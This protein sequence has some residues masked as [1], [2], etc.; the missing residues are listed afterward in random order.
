MRCALF[1]PADWPQ[2]SPTYQAVKVAALPPQRRASPSSG[3]QTVC[4]SALRCLTSP[5]ARERPLPERN[6]HSFPSAG[7]EAR[8]F[9]S[10]TLNPPYTNLL[11]APVRSKASR[12]LKSRKR[13]LAFSRTP[14][15]RLTEKSR[16]CGGL[17]PMENHAVS[18]IIAGVTRCGATFRR[19]D[20]MGFSKCFSGK[21]TRRISLCLTP[22]TG[23]TSPPVFNY[24]QIMDTK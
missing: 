1:L 23:G 11:I 16:S 22:A 5:G 12:C 20:R 4:S 3:R 2:R 7:D 8:R 14:V 18:G 21:P 15:H 17:S 9:P 10:C 6:T 19:L 13:F 24:I